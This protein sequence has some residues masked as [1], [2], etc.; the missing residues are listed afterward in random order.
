MRGMG[1]T[2]SLPAVR[3]T[4][5]V[6]FANLGNTCYLAAALQFLGHCDGFLEFVLG[7]DHDPEHA[8]R[9]QLLPV[10]RGLYA[11]QWWGGR[12]SEGQEA[13]PRPALDVS[14]VLR[15]LCRVNPGGWEARRQND[16]HECWMALV[17]RLH[18]E[19][20][21]AHPADVPVSRATSALFAGHP[22]PPVSCASEREVRL[23][24]Q[25][26]AHW[27]H[28]FRGCHSPLVDEFYG[29]YLSQVV[30]GR[31]GAEYHNFEVLSAL[32]LD[33]PPP[34]PPP[35]RAEEDGEG[36]RPRGGAARGG[37]LPS[38]APGGVDLEECVASLFGD[39]T[40][41]GWRCDRCRAPAPAV[42]RYRCWKPPR[43]LVVVLKRFAHD[44]ARKDGRPL[45]DAG[46]LDLAP[47]SVGPVA[48][49]VLL[50]RGGARRRYELVACVCHVGQTL[51]GGHFWAI[52]RRRRHGGAGSAGGAGGG[53]WTECDDE[54][55]RVLPPEGSAASLNPAGGC[56]MLALSLAP[57][58]PSRR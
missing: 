18:H 24:R 58:R 34:P 26:D 28:A 53:A 25:A 49:R 16:A 43:T 14:G 36:S 51:A 15:V 12:G 27:E 48:D 9:H 40:I 23:A 35:P 33:L 44:R 22:R 8:D 55:V 6:G 47:W 13:P 7:S 1:D 20:G 54:S 10:L 19:A 57:R 2:R 39:E 52:G 11:A 38:R 31:C 32:P 56:Y 42:R 29:Q 3:G 17:E 45:A 4:P 46:D 41:E 30:C 50:G 5:A 21:R 37:R